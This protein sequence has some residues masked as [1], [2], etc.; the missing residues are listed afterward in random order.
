MEGIFLKFN[1]S[2]P[3]TAVALTFVTAKQTLLD[4]EY[5]NEDK[6][7]IMIFF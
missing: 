4:I 7:K 5:E 6:K 3:I 2:C 1:K